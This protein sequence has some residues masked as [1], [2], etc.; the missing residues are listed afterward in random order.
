M[1]MGAPKKNYRGKNHLGRD[2]EVQQTGVLWGGVKKVKWRATIWLQV[3][4]PFISL[5]SILV[6]GYDHTNMT[7]PLP[8]CSAK[9]SMFGLG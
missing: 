7:A 1:R 4:Q 5:C 2:L 3:G 8:V 6:R 9:L